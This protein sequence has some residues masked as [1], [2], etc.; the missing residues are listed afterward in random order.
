MLELSEIHIL[1]DPRSTSPVKS[2][3]RHRSSHRLLFN[4]RV[5]L[6]RMAAL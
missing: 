1:P 3:T 4:R 5:I 2:V 6:L